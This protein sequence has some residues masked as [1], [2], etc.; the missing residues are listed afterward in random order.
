MPADDRAVLVVGESLIDVVLDTDGAR[1]ERVGGSPANV[2]LGLARQGVAVRLV[3]AL[4]PDAR[5]ERIAAHLRADG[6]RI[7]EASFSLARTSTALAEVAH[8]GAATYAFDIDWTLAPGDARLGAAAALHIGSIGAFLEPGASEVEALARD[9]GD[10]IVTFDP[11][12][13]PAL[14]GPRVDALARFERLCALADLVKLSDEDAS[15]LYPDRPGAQVLEHL[16]ALGAAIAVLTRGGEGAIALGPAGVA[17]VV[18]PRVTVRDTIGA[19]DTFTATL[20][21]L[22]VEDPALLRRE[23]PAPLAAALRT[24]ATAAAITVSRA[25]ADLPTRA[26][27][28]GARA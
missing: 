24:A 26:D 12:V 20:V 9:A 18:A 16:R 7:D 19:G 1:T 25:G 21:R 28:D 23:E 10:A 17:E 14:L 27:I 22:L 15:W 6:V 3:T 13:R 4:G 2:A 8:D 5:G 11:N